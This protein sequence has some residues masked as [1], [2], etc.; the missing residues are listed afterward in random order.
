[1][2]MGSE[3]SELN[4]NVINLK[5][6]KN[7]VSFTP[8]YLEGVDTL[9][10]HSSKPIPAISVDCDG[11]FFLR[12]DPKTREIVGIEIEDF[13]GYFVAKHPEFAP[14]WKQMKRDIK[15]N[16]CENES[17]TAFLTIV[18]ELLQKVM[19]KQDCVKL[20]RP[21]ATGQTALL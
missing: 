17:L 9:V 4:N 3:I 10:F 16:K 12:I 6:L 21:I 8:L 20:T 18:Q 14:I 7:I 5:T 13:E 15:K 19:D 11:E 2:A 1:M